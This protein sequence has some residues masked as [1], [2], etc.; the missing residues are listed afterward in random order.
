MRVTATTDAAPRPAGPYSQSTRIGAI[1]QSAG[2]VGLRP[3]GT[4]VEGVIDLAFEDESGWTVVDFKTDREL[5]G[6]LDRYRR[7]VGLYV[8]AIR[9]ATGRE[10]RGIL[11]RI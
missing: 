5:A 10:G 11:M 9:K 3:D 1:V 6:A 8:E 2:Q 7:Q 4:L